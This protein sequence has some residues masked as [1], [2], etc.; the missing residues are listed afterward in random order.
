[1]GVMA[2][3]QGIAM[4]LEAARPDIVVAIGDD[5]ESR[6]YPGAGRVVFAL[7]GDSDVTGPRLVTRNPVEIYEIQWKCTA[8]AW[9]AE[10]SDTIQRFDD[11][12]LLIC[13]VMRAIY[14]E[15]HGAKV[16]AGPNVTR[17]SMSKDVEAL[18][19]GED[20][21]VEYVIGVPVTKGNTKIAA[22]DDVRVGRPSI[23]V[24]PPET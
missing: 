15:V 7:P 14:D 9:I 2:N 13:D 8:Y 11:I 19:F 21:Y 1:M 17:V 4:R 3:I 12:E 24:N 5:E 22:R 23:A 6:Q 10:S 16:G 18:R 20:G